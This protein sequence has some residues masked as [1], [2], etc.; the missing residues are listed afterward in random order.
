MSGRV[1]CSEESVASLREM[2]TQM[3][4]HMTLSTLLT[5]V[6]TILPSSSSTSSPPVTV[7]E[8]VETSAGHT[9]SQQQ[10]LSSSTA[11]ATEPEPT[12][13]LP[14]LAAPG[15]VPAASLAKV[16]SG[17][18][19]VSVDAHDVERRDTSAQQF[20][21]TGGK[22]GI[23]SLPAS[24]DQLW[25]LDEQDPV[26][27]V[28]PNGA[29]LSLETFERILENPQAEP[30]YVRCKPYLKEAPPTGLPLES[31]EL[32]VIYEA[33]R[34][35]FEEVKDFPIVPNTIIAGRYQILQYLD[36]AAFSRAV[37]CID[38]KHHVEVCIKIIRNSKDFFDQSL[39]EIKLLQYINSAGNADENCV[40]QLYDFFY[41][42]EHIFIV[43]ELLRDNLY[44][45][46]RYNR[47]HEEE[48]YFN[49]ARVQ[50]VARQVL[51]ALAFVH[52]MNLMHCDLKPENI[53]IKS[54][55]RCEVRVIDFGSSCFTTDNLS[56][57]IQSR[58]Y[59]A[60]EVILGCHYDGRIDV[61]SLGCILPEL[62]TGQV[63]FHNQSVPGMLARMAGV[64]G[65]FPQRL[66]HE[67]RH[68]C[69]Y[70]TKHGVFYEAVKGSGEEDEGRGIQ[71]H[72]PAVP[73]LETMDLGSKDPHFLDFIKSALTVDYTLR[74]TARALLK[75]PFLQQDYGSVYSPP[76]A[77]A[78]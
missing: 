61:W 15:G 38:L 74:P 78:K 2:L 76:P 77:V 28:L 29:G 23:V 14:P 16:T 52:D 5:E 69:R 30:E 4:L 21:P 59:R 57:Y 19:R 70:V 24:E 67:G 50:S 43:C 13:P 18:S 3:G 34:T 9:H 6:S 45:F 55:S 39:D 49:I 25:D 27:P 10:Q 47:E 44:E 26:A 11:T 20:T 31:F 66:L 64:C 35:G 17:N 53:L 54:Y 72:F 32:R 51:T 33:G 12:E 60:P 56:S 22:Y 37:K 73:S 42:K 36:A 48:V 40:L 71:L 75:H 63:L 62:L 8:G 65:P 46:G 41:Y 68:T 58:C 7:Q 1:V